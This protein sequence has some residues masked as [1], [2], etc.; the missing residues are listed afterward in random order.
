MSKKSQN[1]TTV[2]LNILV[3]LLTWKCM[4]K[5]LRWSAYNAVPTSK[6]NIN[7]SSKG[8]GFE[9]NENEMGFYPKN[10]LTFWKFAN[11]PNFAQKNLVDLLRVY[12][13]CNF[14]YMKLN[15][16]MHQFKKIMTRN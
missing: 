3:E 8:R 13:I 15:L 11:I 4:H 14:F 12:Q 16:G 6:F 1:V 2:S 7:G 10:S 9:S 5:Q